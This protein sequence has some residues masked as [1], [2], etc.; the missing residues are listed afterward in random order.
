MACLDSV[1]ISLVYNYMSYN[2]N[3]VSIWL[4]KVYIAFGLYDH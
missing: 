3:K 4:H 1:K 2:P